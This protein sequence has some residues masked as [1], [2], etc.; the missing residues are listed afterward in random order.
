MGGHLI[1]C[2][3]R[4]TPVERGARCGIARGD[5][6][7]GQ[8]VRAI[9]LVV[10]GAFAA[11]S[12]ALSCAGCSVVMVSRLRPDA[13]L[14]HEPGPRKPGTRGR[15]PSKGARQRS[16]RQ[17]AVRSDTPWESHEVDWYG[18][19]RKSVQLVSHTALW[20][21]VG[22]RPVPIR[23]VLVRDPEGV[24][25]DE[26]FFSTDPTMRAGDIISYFVMRW[27]VCGLG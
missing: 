7:C 19:S 26:A 10:D 16:L 18:G 17:W 12:L 1:G 15:K 2:V 22:A 20:H 24:L 9:I 27:S 11:T 4:K 25:R 23:W 5:G 21:R 14:F 3:L 6:S 8:R 13:R